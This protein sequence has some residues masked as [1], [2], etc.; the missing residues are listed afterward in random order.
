MPVRWGSIGM[1]NL[2]QLQGQRFRRR[3]GIGTALLSLILGLAGCAN[4]PIGIVCTDEARA[5]VMV[6]V[7]DSVSGAGLARGAT[8][9]LQDGAYRDSSV[10]A[11]DDPLPG[12]SVF[13]ATNTYERAGTYTVRVRRPGYALWERQNVLVTRDECHVVAARVRAR[14]QP[15]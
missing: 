6:T 5:S 14:L 13:Y 3:R 9:V 10:F 12:D 8:L 11:L 4:D 7:L 1:R 15:N 2:P